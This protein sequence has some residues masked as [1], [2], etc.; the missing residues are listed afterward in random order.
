MSI[1]IL[2]LMM[3]IDEADNRSGF[4]SCYD[5]N[6]KE[7]RKTTLY[8]KFNQS[9]NRPFVPGLIRTTW[10]FSVSSFHPSFLLPFLPFLIWCTSMHLMGETNIRKLSFNGCAWVLAA[11][12]FAV[13]PAGG[14]DVA[15]AVAPTGGIQLPLSVNSIPSR[16]GSFPTRLRHQQHDHQHLCTQEDCSPLSSVL[17]PWTTLSISFSFPPRAFYHLL[18]VSRPQSLI[19]YFIN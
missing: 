1:S 12:P 7:T 15:A 13:S 18:S 5:R 16:Y 11:V 6:M 8:M 10:Y 9:I 4:G 14:V 19:P 17:L 3:K 2:S